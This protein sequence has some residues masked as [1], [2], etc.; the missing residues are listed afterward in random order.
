M[1]RVSSI[2]HFWRVSSF[3]PADRIPARTDADAKKR[4]LSVLNKALS[5]VSSTALWRVGISG[6]GNAAFTV[7]EVVALPTPDPEL[8]IHLRSTM[9][10]S[11][12]SHPTFSGERKV[13]TSYYAHTVGQDEELQPQLYSWEWAAA[14]PTYPHLHLRRS[15][16]AFHGLGKLH[17]PTG[18]VFFEDVL[19]FLIRDHDVKP[20]REDW[21]EVLE[22]CHRRVSTFA[23]WGGRRAPA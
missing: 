11:Y 4:F 5:A 15:D 19:Q 3:N 16:P 12:E 18:R 10:F 9:R 22:E 23:T 7:P 2:S 8:T 13:A 14:E 20:A 1:T 17:I 6:D 21:A